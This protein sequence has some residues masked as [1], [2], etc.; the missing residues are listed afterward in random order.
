MV[1]KNYTS[2]V[3]ASRSIAAIEAKLAHHNAHQILKKYDERKRVSAIAFI[4][5]VNGADLPFQLPARV[6]QCEQVLRAQV[7]RPQPGT[8]E[9]IKAQAE[10]T[11]WKIVSDWIDA[12]MAMIELSQVEF[13][14]V[15]LPYVYDVANDQTYFERLKEH[16]FKALL[17]SAPAASERG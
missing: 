11:A 5:K 6:K 17:P 10:R 8:F 2:Q 15:F 13:M 12:Q 3:P 7:R 4:V 1:L 9:R 16:G 14:E